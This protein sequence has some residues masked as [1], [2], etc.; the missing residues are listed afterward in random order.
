MNGDAEPVPLLPDLLGFR[1]VPAVL[2]VDWSYLFDLPG[3]PPAQRAKRID[4]RLAASLIQLP[5]AITGVGA[6]DDYAS[7]AIRDLQRGQGVGL[8]SGEGAGPPPRGRAAHPRGG[9]SRPG[10]L[11]AG[12][13]ALVLPAQGGRAPRRGRAPGPGGRPEITFLEPGAEAY[14]FTFG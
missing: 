10:R 7:L 5:Q 12:D 3:R 6:G 4:G 9:R 1:P 2:V 8:P 13:A 14:V 11:A